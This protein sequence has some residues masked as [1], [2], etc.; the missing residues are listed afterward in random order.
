MNF[1]PGAEVDLR[2][3]NTL[4]LPA[5]AQWCTDIQ[6]TADLPATLDFARSRGLAIRVLGGG[7]NVVLP[8]RLPGLT[9]R[10]RSRGIALLEET[11]LAYVV[12]AAAGEPWHPFV[13]H[14]HQQGWHGLENLAL[15][16][17][18]VGAAPIQNIGAYGLEL[19]RFVQEVRGVDTQ[20]GEP[21]TLDAAACGFGYRHSVFKGSL[22]GRLLITDVVFALPRAASPVTH[23][24][25]LAA[26]LSGLAAPDH[27]DV[28]AAVIAIRRRRLP[29]PDL[30]PNA[31]SFFKNPVVSS[32]EFLQLEARWPGIAHWPQEDG[33]VKLAAAWL[34][35]RCG[36]KGYRE[37]G[38]GVHEAQA[39]VLVNFGAGTAAA[40]LAL[41]RRIQD[42]V[43]QRFGLGLEIE[44]V[45]C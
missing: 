23:Y 21:R 18:T 17:G 7:S 39:L 44:P 43:L 36:W 15:I 32:A 20:S 2:G 13:L 34:V 31:G 6:D 8:E 26:E 16:P 38:V 41:A 24:A 4:G 28:L 30:L 9:L 40:L 33:R 5:I 29:D 25:A 37:H 12:R 35:E 14:C 11:S 3:S 42:S 19:A 22:A 1:L 45:L 27:A 10:M